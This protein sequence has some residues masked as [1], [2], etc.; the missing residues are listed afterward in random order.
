MESTKD[1]CAFLLHQMLLYWGSYYWRG[2]IHLLSPTIMII[3]LYI[4]SLKQDL[5]NFCKDRRKYITHTRLKI[6]K[7][8]EYYFCSDVQSLLSSPS[9][10][11]CDISVSK[12]LGFEKS[13]GFGIGKNWYRK[14]VLDS[15]SF[16]FWVS[17]HIDHHHYQQHYHCVNHLL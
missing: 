7:E 4:C 14:K 17:S 8:D 1:L 10:S 2:Q 5:L 6:S 15:I 16:R 3:K 11:E 13:I 12:L 9:P